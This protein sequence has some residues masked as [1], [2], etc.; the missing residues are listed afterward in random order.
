M[1]NVLEVRRSS[2][3]SKS[4]DLRIK[5]ISEETIQNLTLMP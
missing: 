2:G 5:E 3:V 1:S 4:T